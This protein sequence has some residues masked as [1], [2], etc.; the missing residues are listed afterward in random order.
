MSQ[1]DLEASSRMLTAL[2]GDLDETL[3]KWGADEP[4]DAPRALVCLLSLKDSIRDLGLCR[5]ALENR[6]GEA[7]AKY[8]TIIDGIG[9]VRRHKNAK[10]RNWDS[11]RLFAD[12]LD[13]RLVNETTGELVEET[14]L[15]RVKAVYTLAGYN[16]RT[17]ALKARGLDADDY[18][19]SEIRGWQ[20]E[21][22]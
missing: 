11:G 7:L 6:I 3:T 20:L 18:C 1:A 15:D 19:E 8:E 22:K 21:I 12:V 4:L 14:P 5:E 10:R 17:G 13:S 16:A 9:V 2:I